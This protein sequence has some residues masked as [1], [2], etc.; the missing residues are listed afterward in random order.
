MRTGN[1]VEML[2]VRGPV[3]FERLLEKEPISEKIRLCQPLFVPGLFQVAAYAMAMISRIIGLRVDDPELQA[4]VNL[5]MQRANKLE[6]RLLGTNP[7]EV[8]AV[9]D[10]GVLRRVVGGPAV[11][12]EQLDHLAALS[13]METVRLGIT[14]FDYGAHAGLGGS[15][16]YHEAADGL[17]S[18]F[19]EG[20]PA[21]QIVETDQAMARQYRATAEALM[22]S[23]VSGEK[24]R[25]MLESIS[26][27][28]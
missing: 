13:K 21:D 25:A 7:P 1:P 18:V 27:T 5:R 26:S 3:A 22:A 20:A 12:R 23:A 11:M 14:P 19:F 4:R 16:E 17:A 28:L 2:D 24:A 10:E 6:E 9:M 8:W 15:F